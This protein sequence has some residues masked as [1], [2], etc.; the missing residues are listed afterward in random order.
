MQTSD[1]PS[2]TAAVL[3]S[4]AALLRHAAALPTRDGHPS[5]RLLLNIAERLERE[6][7][8]LERGDR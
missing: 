7:D 8:D 1:Q 4:Q 5:N 6:A 2:K 3:R